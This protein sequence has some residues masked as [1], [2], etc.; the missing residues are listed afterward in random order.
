MIP[1]TLR[2]LIVQE[3][4]VVIKVV[5]AILSVYRVM[6]YKGTLKL[7]TISDP[8]SGISTTISDV[9]VALA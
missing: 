9:E 5:L 4:P 3:D 7:S 2:E 8:F 6:S 1:K